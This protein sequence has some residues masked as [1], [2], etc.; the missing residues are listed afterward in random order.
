M[1]R[2]VTIHEVTQGLEARLTFA[3]VLLETVQRTVLLNCASR[4]EVGTRESAVLIV[5]KEVGSYTIGLE[6]Q[7]LQTQGRIACCISTIIREQNGKDKMYKKTIT[8]LQRH[9]QCMG[10]LNLEVFVSERRSKA[11]AGESQR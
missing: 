4:G 9:E 3:C 8:M 6:N 1:P 11:G 7:L 10:T 2:S 5:G